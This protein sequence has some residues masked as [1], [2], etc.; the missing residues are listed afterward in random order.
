MDIF[1]EKWLYQRFLCSFVA[2]F[3]KKTIVHLCV[4]FVIEW[5]NNYIHPVVLSTLVCI[6][7]TTDNAEVSKNVCR[8]IL[9][10]TGENK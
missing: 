10:K 1:M 2:S 4:V 3:N 7:T 6:T 8:K 5:I 9:P